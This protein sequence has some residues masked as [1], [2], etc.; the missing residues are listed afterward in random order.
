VWRTA[1]SGARS[2]RIL[3]KRVSVFLLER[4]PHERK[5]KNT[6]TSF[7]AVNARTHLLCFGVSPTPRKSPV[8]D[9]NQFGQGKVNILETRLLCLPS[10][11]VVVGPNG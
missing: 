9:K 3:A 7:R 2:E 1:R 4:L 10:T 6:G 5:R 8:F 11:K